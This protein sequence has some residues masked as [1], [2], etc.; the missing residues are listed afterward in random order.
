MPSRM[1]QGGQGQLLWLVTWE[2]IIPPRLKQG[3]PLGP[4]GRQ[5]IVVSQCKSQTLAD[6]LLA[7][8]TWPALYTF[9]VKWE[10]RRVQRDVS[11]S[12]RAQQLH[13]TEAEAALGDFGNELGL[14]VG[15]SW[16]FAPHGTLV[17]PAQLPSPEALL[18]GWLWCLRAASA[19]PQAWQQE[20]ASGPLQSRLC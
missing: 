15:D 11:L 9:P 18:Q 5:S 10:G 14:A 20:V 12:H 8:V 7:L 13:L 3:F 6:Q 19:S 2:L 16:P 1:A 4:T 17:R